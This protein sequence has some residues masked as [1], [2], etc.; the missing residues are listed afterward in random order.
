MGGGAPVISS[1]VAPVPSACLSLERTAQASEVEP[2]WSLS[3]RAQDGGMPMCQ[4][5]PHGVAPP[6]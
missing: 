3:P 2:K 4:V 1:R 6:G 5:M